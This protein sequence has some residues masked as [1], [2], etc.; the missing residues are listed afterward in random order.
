VAETAEKHLG[1]SL[2]SGRLAGEELERT[3]EL[4]LKAVD[5]KIDGQANYV[6]WRDSVMPI[7]RP[8]KDFRSEIVLPAAD[9]GDVTAHRWRQRLCIKDEAGTRR[10]EEQIAKVKAGAKLRTRRICELQDAGIHG[11]GGG[12]NEWYTPPEFLDVARQVL[13]HIGLDPASCVAAQETVRA[14]N[15]YT[16][17]SDGLKRRWSGT[18]WLNPP[19]SQPLV[20]QFVEK[21]VAEFRAGNVTAAILLSSNGTDAAWFHHAA[22][23]A[24]AICFTKGR[25]KFVDANGAGG[26]DR[27][28]PPSGSAFLYFGPDVLRFHE[29]FAKFGTMM[30]PWHAKAAIA[31]EAAE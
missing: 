15:F 14:D 17:D 12:A 26:R 11:T 1:R 25:I 13:G 30:V 20:A 31:A 23:A 29:V 6:V 21:L 9:P 16:K 2:R 7:G 19:Y 4:L 24:T 27:V 3:L 5:G 22:E 8:K 10:N 18:V 28:A